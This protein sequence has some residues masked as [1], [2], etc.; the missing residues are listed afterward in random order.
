MSTEQVTQVWI[1]ADLPPELLKSVKRNFAG[2][3]FLNGEIGDSELNKIAVVLAEDPLPDPVVEKMTDLRWVHVTRGG[4]YP[5]LTP[6]IRSRPVQVTCTKGVHGPT[7]SEFALGLILAM[8]KGFPQL[9]EAQSRKKWLRT[10][11]QQ[12]AGLTL[13]VVGLGTV[14]SDLARK[15]K[16][17]NLKVI[18]TKRT[19][20]FKP[21]CVDEIGP[22][23]FLDRLLPQSD[24]VV[25]CL[26]SIP[27]T[28]KIMGE[29]ELRSMKSSAYLINLTAGRAI[30][31]ALLVRALKEKWI[32]GA[33]LD[34]L[35]RQPLPSDSELWDLPNVMITPRVSGLREKKWDQVVAIFTGNFQLFLEGKKLQNMVD[36]EKGY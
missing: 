23:E 2:A 6:A 14:G 22:P 15:A 19:V 33:A 31:E 11:P 28:E 34:A 24:F 1:R 25:L 18:G 16:A 12:I 8:A 27:S 21:D 13:G 9:W 5:Y 32:A 30:E 3:K 4:A 20:E 35:P 10:V 7:F 29:K 36:K 26:P 17:M